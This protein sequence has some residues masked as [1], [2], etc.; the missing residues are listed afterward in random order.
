MEKARS[1]EELRSGELA[2]RA[3]V[4][5]D[6]LRV[7]ERRGLLPPPRRAGNGYRLYPPES[8]ARV[9]LIQRAL[10]LGFTLPEL[11][12]FLRGRESGQPPCRDVRAVAAKRLGEV[13]AAIADLE[14]L[15]E[16]LAALLSE[17][18]ASL[19][20][21][22]GARLR[23]FLERLPRSRSRNAAAAVVARRFSRSP[24]ARK[25]ENS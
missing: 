9:Q 1:P 12:G 20:A 15:R 11:A 21:G 22:R 18:D 3:G 13:E 19:A 10:S 6:T 5:A 16:S 4:S 8:L 7:Y 14:E 2:Q 23:R 24:G 17:W 25:K